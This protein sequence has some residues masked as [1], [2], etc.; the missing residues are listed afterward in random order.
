[1]EPNVRIQHARRKTPIQNE[2]LEAMCMRG[3]C[4]MIERIM[5]LAFSNDF[6]APEA[7]P[8]SGGQ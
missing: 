8:L 2:G 4:R 7:D 3:V 5:L 1:M 6:L